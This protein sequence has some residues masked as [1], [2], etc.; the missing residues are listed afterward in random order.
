M[1]EWVHDLIGQPWSRERNCWWLVRH[2]FSTQY[3]ID[4]PEVNIDDPSRDNVRAI[5]HAAHT[6]GWRP[7]T[8][9][10]QDRD[11]VLLRTRSGDRHVGVMVRAGG[12]LR[13]LHCE[14]NAGRSWPGIVW[15]Q[16]DSVLL[17]YDQPEF[18]RYTAG[19]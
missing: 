6:S 11:I 9:R 8:G 4:M 7:A 18:W 5:H 15:E 16:L 1:N 13:L 19:S 14:G 12:S 17:R 2:V 10:P 3:G